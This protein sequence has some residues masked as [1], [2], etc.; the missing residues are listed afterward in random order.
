MK[1]KQPILGLVALFIV[2][3]IVGLYTYIG[4]L[5]LGIFLLFGLAYGII[6]ERSRFC[7]A[8]AFRDLFITRDSRLTRGVAIGTLTA[9]IGFSLLMLLGIRNPKILPVG[10]H[11][12]LGGV[13]F[14]FGMVLAGGCAS[15]TLFRVGEGYV[16][17]W[18]ALIGTL[19]GMVLLAYTWPYLWYN[20][21]QY[22]PKIWL[23]DY[24]GWSRSILL[25]IS[26]LLVY[27]IT[28]TILEKR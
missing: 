4:L 25:T 3:L 18:F 19:F 26:L 13:L 22:Q 20:Y 21:I 14:G 23:V 15:G 6:L 17:L 5:E 11:T 12:L 28:V 27:Y 1:L 24:L 2:F 9:T 8:S 10:L 7:F 16:T